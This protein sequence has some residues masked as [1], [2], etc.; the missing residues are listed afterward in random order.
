M[1][2][3]TDRV[4]LV[5][6]LAPM[7]WGSTYAVTTELLPD[8]RPLLAGLLRALPAG[9]ALSAV[10]R[11]RPHG[12]WWIRSAALG[13][14]YIGIFFPLLFLAAYRLPGG[15]AAILGSVGPLVTLG[16]AAGVLHERPTTRKAVAGVAGV[17]GVALVM[18]QADVAIDAVGIVAGVAGT[19]SM[20]SATV[21]AKRWGRPEGVGPLA[22]TGWQLTTGG[23]MIAPLA[24]AVEGFPPAL[25]GGNLLGYG[26]LTTVNTALAY[27][28][29]FRGIGRLPANSIAF[30]SLCSPLTAATIGWLVLGQ[31]MTAVQL[32]GMVIAGAGSLA[33]ASR[34]GSATRGDEHAEGVVMWNHHAE[35]VIPQD[36]A[37]IAATIDRL[38]RDRWGERC[39]P[40]IPLD[41]SGRRV[42]A[43]P[44]ADDPCEIDAWLTWELAPEPGGTLVRVTLDEVDPGPDPTEALE[45]LLDAL[46]ERTP[47]G[48]V[49]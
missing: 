1:R 44:C 41:A 48:A 4:L 43:L 31:S 46:T 32:L 38:V 23:L 24:I 37:R 49:D 25:D 40:V 20:A 35:R 12:I 45:Q 8:D 6:A 11:S 10:T 33:G 39:R 3:R 28:L 22:F 26:Y 34:W 9:L 21:L 5:T 42:D 18:L 2:V 7:A 29:W 19:C 16:L 30:L 47:A 17:A 13:A 15:L 36:A 14:L 27:W